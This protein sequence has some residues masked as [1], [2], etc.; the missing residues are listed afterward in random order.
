MQIMHST[1]G[2][3][4]TTF[5]HALKLWAIPAADFKIEINF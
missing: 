5:F 2:N 4:F 3:I 1:G